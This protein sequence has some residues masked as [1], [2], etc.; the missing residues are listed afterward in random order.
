MNDLLALKTDIAFPFSLLASR[1]RTYVHSIFKTI[2]LLPI[3]KLINP[4]DYS[5]I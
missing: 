1:T 4:N 3:G 5:R 2:S